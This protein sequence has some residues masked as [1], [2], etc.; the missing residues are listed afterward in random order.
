MNGI[1]LTQLKSQ[2][3]PAEIT[4][5]SLE[6]DIYLSYALR[7][8]TL[9]MIVDEDGL[10]L[11]AHSIDQMHSMLRDVPVARASLVMQTPYEE[12]IGLHGVQGVEGV[13]LGW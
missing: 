10:P 12:M 11:K 9:R 8:E 5:Q 3:A 1:T 6:G 13:P 4:V 7:D 2:P